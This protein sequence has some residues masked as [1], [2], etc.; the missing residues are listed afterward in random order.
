MVIS[1]G[2]Q[3]RL[4]AAPELTPLADHNNA[5]RTVTPPQQPTVEPTVVDVANELGGRQRKPS[6][7]SLASQKSDLCTRWDRYWVVDF[8]II[9]VQ[10]VLY[11]TR[12]LRLAVLRAHCR[13]D[14][15]IKCHVLHQCRHDSIRSSQSTPIVWQF[16]F[17]ITTQQLH[18][19]TV[20]VWLAEHSYTN[21]D[22][23]RFTIGKNKC[24]PSV[25]IE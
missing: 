3:R 13:R 1:T 9:H 23:S 7:T 4:R 17:R 22:S 14:I 8:L 11:V 18:K 20:A 6:T 15:T 2:E 25:H 24:A 21:R 5:R 16:T 12:I 19:T 10:H